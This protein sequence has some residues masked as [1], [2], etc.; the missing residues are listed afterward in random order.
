MNVL[1]INSGSSSLKFGLFGAEMTPL[2]RGQA[3][4]P[5]ELF[6]R[7]ALTPDAIGHRIVHGGTLHH[8]P[9]LIDESVMRDLRSL[10]ELA[11]IHMP[12]AVEAIEA[13]AAAY[14]GIMASSGK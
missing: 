3:K 13:T 1:A 4:D 10:V 2:Q 11:P 8:R 12:P 7:L 14:P 9:C 5:K 6:S